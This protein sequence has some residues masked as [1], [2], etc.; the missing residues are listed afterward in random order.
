MVL[1]SWN[2]RR[3]L[4]VLLE[5]IERQTIRDRIEVIVIDNGSDDGT[6]EWLASA[7]AP[8]GIRLFRYTENMGACIARNAG[9]KLARA[10]FVC[11]ID[12]DA[13]L[14]SPN[15]I[16][17]C[18]QE[19]E[20][21]PECD[22]ISCPI[23]KN[24]ERTDP[25]LLG[26]YVTPDFHYDGWSCR[27]RMDSPMLFSTCFAVWRKETLT[28]VRGF[29]PW[30]FWGIED[31]DLALRVYWKRRREQRV[32]YTM[33]DDVHVLHEMSDK[34]RLYSKNDFARQFFR[35]ERQRLYMVLSSLGVFMFFRILLR[36]PFRAR[37]MN[38]AYDNTL[39]RWQLFRGSVLLS[40]PRVL[41][42]PK[43][44][45]DVRRD[46]L[47]RTPMPEPVPTSS[48]TQLVGEA[49]C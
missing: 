16:D 47:A 6:P 32:A 2:R 46:H 36:T 39:S 24:R 4:A 41:A 35:F 26:G 11:F 43:N 31:V 18:L 14:L 3:E 34:G 48:P 40:L 42:L 49:A 21:Q 1:V 7:E 12:S 23:W 45:F 27:N 17:R 30:Y 19:F 20:V 13:E 28:E 22:A 5:S 29:D 10:P 37:R 8:E 44:V 15:V 38:A 9:I 33:V 25:W